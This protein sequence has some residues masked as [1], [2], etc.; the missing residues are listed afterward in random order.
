MSLDHL[1]YL[2]VMAA[3][4]VVTVP[5]EVVLGARVYRRPRRAVATVLPAA[6]AFAVWDVVAI[7][8]DE[9]SFAPRYV[10]G[11]RVG[12]LPI[13]EV[14]FFLVIPLCTL[15]TFEAVQRVLEAVRR[16]A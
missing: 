1:Q 9:W 14:S 15:L 2:L 4:L 6:A 8:R 3:C 10:T 5:L 12:P 16:G 7:A 11:L 13:E